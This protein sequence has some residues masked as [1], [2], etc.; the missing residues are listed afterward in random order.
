MNLAHQRILMF[1]EAATLAHVGRPLVLARALTAHGCEV[2]FARPASYAW[3]THDDALET[4]DL[5]CQPSR[6]F[7]RRLDTGRPLYDLSTLENYVADDL[8]LIRAFRPDCIVGDFRLS[9]SVSARLA[10]IPYATICDAYW[11]PEAPLD[12]VLPV[13]PFTR[14]TPITFAARLFRAVAPIAFRIHARPIEALR[15]AHGLPGFNHDLRYC[16]TDADLRLFANPSALFPE[17]R[18]HAGAQFVGPVAWSPSA[19]LPDDFPDEAGIIYVSMGSSGN[20]EVLARLFD[21]LLRFD[22]P[23]VVTTAGRRT[24]PAPKSSRFHLYDFLP[25]PQALARVRLMVC[26]GGSPSTNQALVAGIP[27]LGIPSNM[28]QFLNMKAIETYG[29]GLTCR[30]DRSSPSLLTRT[31]ERLL[32]EETCREHAAALAASITTDDSPPAEYLK[33]LLG[34]PAP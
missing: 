12:P 33:A 7:A 4:V 17:V 9:L 14:F 2:V 34:K 23:V 16:Y 13:L 22:A 1:A 11:S 20:V 5:R 21:A 24:P 30:A 6:E 32:S 28:D 26:N 27:I 18:S 3:M 15:R 31:L 19:P 10:G 25:G 29:A 8:A